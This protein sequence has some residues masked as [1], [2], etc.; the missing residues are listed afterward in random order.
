MLIAHLPA[1]YLLS[2]EL[3]R[4]L[5]TERHLWLGLLAGLLPD[6][7]LLYFYLFDGR[8]HLH[9]SYWTHL[10]ACWMLVAALAFTVQL[11]SAASRSATVLVFANVLL[12]LLLDTV[13]GGICWLYPLSAK[14]LQLFEVPARTVGG[15]AYLLSFVLH[16]TF[17][18]ELAVVIGAV[19]VWLRSR[20][21]RSPHH[22]T[23][24]PRS[25]PATPPAVTL[26]RSSEEL[27]IFRR[28]VSRAR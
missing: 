7:D 1:S 23:R 26:L 20:R 14:S 25:T 13:V 17:L 16:W 4:R 28:G 21:R 5:G 6:L 9:H 12:H 18:L 8:Q 2:R 15:H 22:E 11:W 19:W 27:S 24:S 3:Q 10:P